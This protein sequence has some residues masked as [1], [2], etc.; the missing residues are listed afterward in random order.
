[1]LSSLEQR[2]DLGVP[3]QN[4]IIDLVDVGLLELAADAAE[5]SPLAGA[6]ATNSLWF[7]YGKSRN[8][9]KLDRSYA[10]LRSG[11]RV[12]RHHRGCTGGF[13]R[14]FGLGRC[15]ARCP[16]YPTPF[17]LK[18]PDTTCALLSVHQPQAISIC[19]VFYSA[20]AHPQQQE[21][22]HQQN[23]SGTGRLS[24]FSSFSH[25]LAGTTCDE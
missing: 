9:W 24:W 1:M 17:P 13:L 4:A 23:P 6:A 19:S 11:R 12:W 8:R 25:G 21:H 20:P 18:S 22:W 14:V 10:G 3:P 2:G 16:W 5:E 15:E 7:V